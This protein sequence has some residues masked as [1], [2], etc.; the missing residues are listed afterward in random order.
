MGMG[1]CA[2][3][4]P[5]YIGHTHGKFTIQ[6]RIHVI[7]QCMHMGGSWKHHAYTCRCHPLL[8]GQQH[9][10]YIEHGHGKMIMHT[11]L[12]PQMPIQCTWSWPCLN[13][14]TWP[15]MAMDLW[16]CIAASALRDWLRSPL[17]PQEA[18]EAASGPGFQLQMASNLLRIPP[19]FAPPAQNP[20]LFFYT[21]WLQVPN[22]FVTFSLP[23]HC[24]CQR[25]IYKLDSI[26]ATS[27]GRFVRIVFLVGLICL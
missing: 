5:S 4:C 23:D 19:E 9:A 11:S 26:G 21:I 27:G 6:F 8:H 2:W 10:A 12:S 24:F 3:P 22:N 16:A 17:P 7:S 14:C 1:Q 15:F 18:I 13:V 25:T 20:S